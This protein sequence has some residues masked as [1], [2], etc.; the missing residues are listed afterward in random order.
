MY[1]INPPRSVF[2]HNFI[3]DLR[4]LKLTLTNFHDCIGRRKRPSLP[5]S[6][7]IMKLTLSFSYK[8]QLVVAT[9]LKKYDSKWVHHFPKF[10][11]KKSNKKS[12]EPPPTN[13]FLFPKRLATTRQGHRIP[14]L[15]GIS[16][17]ILGLFF[18]FG[19]RLDSPLS[20]RKR[21]I[22]PEMKKRLE[23]A[24]LLLNF[25]LFERDMIR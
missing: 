20:P 23:N 17:G 14:W 8:N 15:Q 24:P 9:P 19:K 6:N 22:A 18:S 25:H 5:A 13:H 12:L 16:L 2:M 1:G 11:V 3:L 4:N 21:N 10:F 7:W